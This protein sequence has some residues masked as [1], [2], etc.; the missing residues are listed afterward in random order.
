MTKHKDTD[1]LAHWAGQEGSAYVER[2]PHS[3]AEYEALY[4]KDYGVSRQ[5][6]N[7]A[8]LGELP[9][10][11]SV[12]EVGANVGV[13][14][15]FLRTMGFSHLVG[16]DIN[17]DAVREAGKL[18]PKVE[19]KQGSGFDLQFEDNSFDMVYTSGVLIHVAP[20]DALDVM[21]EM[22]RTSR[23]YIWGFEYYAPSYEEVTYRGQS[24]RLWKTDFAKMFAD[25]FPDLTLVYE[26]KY[27]MP[28]GNVSQ[29]YLLKKKS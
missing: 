13:Q 4:A 17:A 14:L 18:H 2:N 21:R 28:D 3:M 19:V 23:S 1:Q 27:P 11:L 29:M 6:M 7:E 22:H 24:D 12:L 10:D 20:T 8:C 9:R 15:E 5:A 16:I 26:K 25:N